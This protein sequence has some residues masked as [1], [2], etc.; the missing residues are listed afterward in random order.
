MEDSEIKDRLQVSI[1][2]MTRT[3]DN[4]RRLEEVSEMEQEL[5]NI[6]D[7]LTA[8]RTLVIEQKRNWNIKSGNLPRKIHEQST[9]DLKHLLQEVGICI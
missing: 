6:D 5:H 4:F 9:S 8:I 7:Q 1:L 3:I 2:D